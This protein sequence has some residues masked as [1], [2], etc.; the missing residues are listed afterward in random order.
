[1]PAGGDHLI[2]TA[3]VDLGEGQSNA[4]VGTGDEHVLHVSQL[5]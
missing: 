4:T 1:L 2:T 3:S 5:P